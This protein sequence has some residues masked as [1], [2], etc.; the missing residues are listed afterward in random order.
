MTDSYQSVTTHT[1]AQGH[2]EER[3]I[4]SDSG[5]DFGPRP[6]VT[7][8]DSGV[9]LSGPRDTVSRDT[10]SGTRHTRE[11]QQPSQALKI[12]GCAKCQLRRRERA[13]GTVCVC[14]SDAPSDESV[15]RRRFVGGKRLQPCE[16]PIVL[17]CVGLGLLMM[18][19]VFRGVVWSDWLDGM[20]WLSVLL[21]LPY[22]YAFA[23]FYYYYACAVLVSPGYPPHVDPEQGVE[24]SHPCSRCHSERYPRTHH[25]T[26]CGHCVMKMDHHCPWVA[27]CVGHFNYG[28]FFLFLIYASICAACSTGLIIV[29]VCTGYLSAVPYTTAGPVVFFG[30]ILGFG[31]TASA[32]YMLSFHVTL[33]KTN[34]TTIE[35]YDNAGNRRSAKNQGLEYLSD[36]DLGVKA[37]IRQVLGCS[38]GRAMLLPSIL[39]PETDGTAWRLNPALEERERE[40]EERERLGVDTGLDVVSER[41]PLTSETGDDG[42]AVFDTQ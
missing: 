23:M 21:T 37:N 33:I 35:F 11:R 25:C 36:Y 9:M 7:P 12:I 17:F 42:V 22:A 41:T 8:V 2:G 16:V 32:L 39:V 29:A 31:L 1:S 10:A 13:S 3:D 19:V 27:G 5:S 26:W 38:L 15:K 18:V 40:M 4:E 30:A 28:Y 34:Q 6:P 24:D 20:T 14:G